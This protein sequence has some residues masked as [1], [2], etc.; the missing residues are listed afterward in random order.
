MSIATSEHSGSARPV[1]VNWLLRT[2][3]LLCFVGHGAFGIITKADWLPFFRVVNL[4]DYVSWHLMPLIGAMD[5][6]IGVLCFW[7][8]MRIVVI[9]G[10]FWCLLTALMRPLAGMSLFEFFERAGNYGAPILLLLSTQTH[11]PGLRAWFAKLHPSPLAPVATKRLIHLAVGFTSLLL[12]GH[13]GFGLVLEKELLARHY[14]SIGWHQMGGY[15][16]VR[17]IG[18]VEI[19]AAIAV[20]V[21]PV[22]V[23]LLGI[24][25]WKLATELLYPIS[26]APIW[27]TIERAGSYI[28]PVVAVVLYSTLKAGRSECLDNQRFANQPADIP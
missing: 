12:M 9:W 27:E 23:L 20:V 14:G 7:R 17:A 24:S 22:R 2:S 26:G 16:V 3:I 18:A 1:A 15:S 28:V 5:I 10:I 13:G 8:P 25:A 21:F 4:P 19:A 11:E 6:A